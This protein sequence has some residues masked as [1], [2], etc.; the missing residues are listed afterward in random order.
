[1]LKKSVSKL[2]GLLEKLD[3]ILACQCDDK[4][5]RLGTSMSPVQQILS[6]Y[7]LASKYGVTV[8]KMMLV[9]CHSHV[10]GLDFNEAPLVPDF[11]IAESLA[12]SISIERCLSVRANGPVAG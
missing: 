1:M 2:Q 8:H 7:L 4:S 12:R 6:A 11:E 10:C 9:Q 5:T 3:S